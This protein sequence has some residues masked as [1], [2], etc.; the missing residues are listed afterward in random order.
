MRIFLFTIFF[1]VSAHT[2]GQ[3]TM[4]QLRQVEH[5]NYIPA[6]IHSE[7]TVVVV[8]TPPI[9]NHYKH[10][11]D[12]QQLSEQGHNALKKMGLDVIAYI[13]HDDLNADRYLQH[14]YAK[15]LKD[16]NVRH[17]LFLSFIHNAY[18]IVLGTF[19]DDARIIAN[20]SKVFRVQSDKLNHLLY[21]FGREI[22]RT[23]YTFGNFLIPEKPE[24]LDNISI[25]DNLHLKN[26]PGQLRRSLLAVERFEQISLPKNAGEDVTTAVHVYNQVVVEKNTA[27]EKIIAKYP[28]DYVLIDPMSDEDLLR[29]RY[30]FVLRSLHTSGESIRKILNYK[31]NPNETDYV[32]IIPIMPDN[33]TIKTIRKD[34]IVTK[35]YIR[36]NITKNVHVGKWDADEDWQKALAHFINNMIQSMGARK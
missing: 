8:K 5:G 14:A 20:G 15:I 13:N 25:V 3:H 24:Y 16:R 11:G 6:S 9:Q 26:Y 29:R 23:Q 21:N 19:S 12:W 10:T 18:E 4:Y 31:L 34:G 28:F 27:L 1:A 33:T 2:I 36:Q 7:R 22:R 17:I 35:F 30:Q 32:S